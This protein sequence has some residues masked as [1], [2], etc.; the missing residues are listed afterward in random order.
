MTES[1]CCTPETNT[2]LS[3]NYT[4]IK[5]KKE[6]DPPPK[7]EHIPSPAPQTDVITNPSN[8]T[9]Q[10]EKNNQNEINGKHDNS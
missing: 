6:T 1:L 4:S 2:T 9:Y 7:K 3:I 10:K 8:R 5:K